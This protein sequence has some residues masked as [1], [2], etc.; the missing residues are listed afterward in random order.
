MVSDVNVHIVLK[1]SNNRRLIAEGSMA[2]VIDIL[3]E[4]GREVLAERERLATV[5]MPP[6]PSTPEQ[7]DQQSAK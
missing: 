3:R 4:L 1:G 7:N 5:P 6:L 2:L